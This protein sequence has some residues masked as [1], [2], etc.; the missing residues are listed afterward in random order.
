MPTLQAAID[1]LQDAIN[2]G[3]FSDAKVDFPASL[4]RQ[5]KHRGSLSQK[6]EFW[7]HKLADEYLNPPEKIAP[8]GTKVADS[9]LPVLALFEKAAGK[10]QYP[11]IWL[12]LADGQPVITS[13]AAAHSKNPGHLYVK[14]PDSIGYAGKVSPTGEFFPV[15]AL[16]PAGSKEI[17]DLLTRLGADPI[18]VATEYAKLTGRCCFCDKHLDNEKSVAVGYGPTCAKNYQLPYGVNAMHEANAKKAVVITNPVANP[19][20]AQGRLK[21]DDMIASVRS[22]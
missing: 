22:A 15:Q 1:T 3:H 20:A 5:F 13:R 12:C 2:E 18:G 17:A 19:I 21:L 4:I 6:Q 11:T 10:L 8:V 7:A 9:F 14:L 16:S